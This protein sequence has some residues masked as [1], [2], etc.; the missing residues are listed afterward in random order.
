MASAYDVYDAFRSISSLNPMIFLDYD[1]TLV[2]IVLNPWEAVADRDLLELLSD[3]SNRYETFLVTGRSLSDIET[4]VPIE[5]NLIA[6][7][8]SVTKV[9]GKSPTFVP[10]FNRYVAL[11]RQ[12]MEKYEG[13]PK[14]YPGLR[15]FDKGGGLLFHTGLMDK[16]LEKDL[17]LKLSNMASEAGMILYSGYNIF[18]LRIPRVSKGTAIRKL[19][20][21]NRNAMIAGDEGTDE[22]AFELNIDALKVKVREG[23]T[24][25]DF[26]LHDVKEMRTALSLIAYS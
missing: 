2:D 15:I 5:I 12:L 23:N 6:L 1:G 14:I 26:T 24:I 13:L 17:H 22:E 20:V 25:A 3:L 21:G 10:G 19:R 8:G 11:C 4:L 9:K 16:K 7:H 18:E